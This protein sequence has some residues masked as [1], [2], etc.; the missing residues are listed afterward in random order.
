MTKHLL[1]IMAFVAALAAFPGN[2]NASAAL[3]AAQKEWTFL[4]F[5][6][7]HNSLDYFGLMNM[8]QMEEVG[9][10]EKVNIVVQWASYGHADT[11]RILVLKS[12]DPDK[13]TSPV[14][15]SLPT[16]DMG[17]S[18][19]LEKFLEWG[20]TNYPAKHY[21][22]SVWNHGNGWHLMGTRAPSN[23][24]I[25]P[26]DISYDDRSGNVITTEQLGLAMKHFSQFLGR[27][28]DIYGS[29]ACLMAMAEVAS[30]MIDSVDYFVGSEDVEPGEG[31]P[32]A[33]FMKKWTEMSGAAPVEVAKLL[34]KEYLAAYTAGVY[35]IQ[36]VTMSVMDLNFLPAFNRSVANLTAELVK[37]NSDEMKKAHEAASNTQEFTLGDYKDTGD[38]LDLISEQV[39]AKSQTEAIVG[40]RSAM[41]KLVVANDVSP[42]FRAHGVAMWIP[43]MSYEYDQYAKRYSGLV[44]AKETGWGE[45]LKMMIA[46]Q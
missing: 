6:N 25:T 44:F 11:Q 42:S 24:G 28:V 33:P 38:F 27:K 22:V 18:K 1:A 19:E 15:D 21:F 2:A 12:D 46:T 7:G 41:E 5:L 8:K 4:L 10:N 17:D 14:V 32:Y 34:S 40:V 37:M 9:S 29:D 43:T 13:V 36:E 16:V 35:G 3:P 26:M 23:T 31:W 45:F 30:E 39:T 20:A